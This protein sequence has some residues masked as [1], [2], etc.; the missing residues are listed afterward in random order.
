MGMKQRAR[1]PKFQEHFKQ[2]QLF[3]N[4][5]ADYEKSH[6]I[7]AISFELSHCDDER[8]Y[9]NYTQL[10]NNIDYDLAKAVAINVNGVLPDKPVRPNHGKKDPTLSQIYFVPKVPT[11]ATRRIAVLIADGFNMVEVEAIRSL[12]AAGKATT[13]II[14]PR[15]GK[16][17]SQGQAIGTGSGIVADHHYEG[18]RSTMFDAI[19]IPSGEHAKSLI[20]NGRAIH[21][22]RE[23]FGH[24]KPIGAIGSGEFG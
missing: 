17:Y 24:C 18:Q 15:R 5:L 11:I 12:L 2:A 16:I 7:A 23:A 9:K 6:L 22:I 21:W 10:L 20:T 4:S 3:Y 8:V 19:F 13:W 14:G 1:T